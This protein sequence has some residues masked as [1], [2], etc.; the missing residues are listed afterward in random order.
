MERLNQALGLLGY[1]TGQAAHVRSN[2]LH[3]I[4]LFAAAQKDVELEQ[5]CERE[6]QS[7]RSAAGV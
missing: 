4:L 2:L 5:A 6:I 7:I 1:K 3:A